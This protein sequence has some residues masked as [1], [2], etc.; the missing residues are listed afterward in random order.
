M[1]K[2]KRSLYKYF[3]II[4]LSLWGACVVAKGDDIEKRKIIEK[5]YI[6]QKEVLL[7]ITNSFGKVHINTTSGNE[8]TVKIEIIARNRSAERALEVID[9]VDI[10]ISESGNEIKFVTEINSGLNN[11]GSENFE[12]NY[13][14]TMPSVNPLRLKNSFGDSYV[15][16]LSSAVDITIAYGDVRIKNLTGDTK[17]KV[18]FGDGDIES[19]SSGHIEIKYSDV[20]FEKLGNVKMVQGFSEVD[21]DEAN[22]INITSKY[23]ELDIG[24]VQGIKGYVGFTDFSL[25][26]LSKEIDLETSYVGGFSVDRVSKNF[27]RINITGKFGGYE[28]DFEEGTNANFEVEVK[29]S[30]FDLDN[31]NAVLNYKN[32]SEFRGEYRGKIGNGSGGRISI[33]SSYGDVEFN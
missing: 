28:L 23:G 27:D 14:I 17:L 15:G 24:T 9:K 29:F 3:G 12:I 26:Y 2:M 6:V 4:V 1:K 10:D 11:R 19:I 31:P 22:T 21:I 13:D 20:D 18:S 8:I 16:N 25:E 5:G 32:K 33:Y 30:D 7:N